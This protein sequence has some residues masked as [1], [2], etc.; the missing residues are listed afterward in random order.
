L[1]FVFGKSDNSFQDYLKCGGFPSIADLSG[2]VDRINDILDGIYNTV[3]V[4]DVIAKNKIKDEELLQK[5]VMFMADNVGNPTSPNS[6]VN[7][8]VSEKRIEN[9]KKSPAVLIIAN[10]SLQ[11]KVNRSEIIRFQEKHPKFRTNWQQCTI[12]P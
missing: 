3:I 5:I 1:T 4:K 2:N 8:L 9:T 6:I 12:F 10:D 11:F 7:S